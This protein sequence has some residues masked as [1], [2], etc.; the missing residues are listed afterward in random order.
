MSYHVLI[1]EDETVTRGAIAENLRS[2]LPGARLALAE[3]GQQAVDLA[4]TLPRLDLVFMDVKMPVMDGLQAAR[5]LRTMWENCQIV[6][7]TAYSDFAF[8]REALDLGAADYL[9]KPFSQTGLIA[10]VQKATSRLKLLEQTQEKLTEAQAE[11]ERLSE[12]VDERT[13]LDVAS[14]ALDDEA[15][16]YLGAVSSGAFA[17]VRCPQGFSP[18]RAAGLLRGAQWES[19]L[20]VLLRIREEYVFLLVCSSME[21]DVSAIVEN[22]LTGLCGKIRRLMHAELTAA[23]SDTFHSLHRAAGACF[24]C[25][26]AVPGTGEPPAVRWLRENGAEAYALGKPTAFRMDESGLDTLFRYFALQKF[27]LAVCQR[28]L[29]ARMGEAAEAQLG[30]TE[31]FLAA[32]RTRLNAC[33]TMR[34]LSDA[35]REVCQAL[36]AVPAAPEPPAPH[37]DDTEAQIKEYLLAH[38]AEEIT[39]E[40][41]SSA[42]GYSRTYFSKLFKRLF[43]KNFVA[44]LTD[45][46]IEEA[47]R[48]LK[49]E[50]LGVREVAVRT[51][52]RDSA[53]FSSTFRKLTGQ[54]PTEYQEA[55]RAKE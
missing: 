38:F 55:V 9:L 14:G 11:R 27:S 32:A 2:I 35:A 13:L 43:D 18:K 42:L 51:G 49:N 36:A 29:L 28:H 53:Y 4:R 40:S 23:V 19:R 5:E 44:Y 47:K 16:E 3:N 1:A 37:E 34:E 33:E 39:L 41:I 24:R 54:T 30:E 20:R 7:L 6:F 46:R 17:V 52:F 50:Q 21:E 10:A 22:R 15:G 25:Y 48:L 8:M 31:E 12:L 45:L 26:A